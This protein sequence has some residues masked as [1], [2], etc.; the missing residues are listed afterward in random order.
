[1]RG[2]CGENTTPKQQQQKSYKQLTYH[3]VSN[4][5]FGFTDYSSIFIEK[6]ENHYQ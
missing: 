5:L 2:G 6:K 4:T 3:F 1:M